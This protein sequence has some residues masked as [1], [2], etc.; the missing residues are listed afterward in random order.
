MNWRE[1]NKNDQTMLIAGMLSAALLV[2]LM[3]AISLKGP[4]DKAQ[5]VI[6]AAKKAKNDIWVEKYNAELRRQGD[7]P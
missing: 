6:D 2:M 4:E 7:N 3:V 5:A 1:L